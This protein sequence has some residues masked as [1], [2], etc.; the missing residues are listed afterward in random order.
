VGGIRVSVRPAVSQETRPSGAAARVRLSN[1]VRREGELVSLT[2]SDVV[3]TREGQTQT[4]PLDQVSRVDRTT[5]NVRNGVL[6]GLLLGFAGGYLSSCGS[7]DE[8]DCWPE[9]GALFA[10]IG[11]GTGAL[12]GA[13]M[14]R[15]SAENRVLYSAP[16]STVS[17]APR[18][19]PS[20]TSLETTVRF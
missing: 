13:G 16:R 20:R 9:A 11:A 14:N 2:A 10:G 4:F 19:S 5:H 1:G 8:E 7:G 15:A 17:V 12:I 18:V 6:W 3:I